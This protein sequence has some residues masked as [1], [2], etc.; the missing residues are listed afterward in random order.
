[1]A[2][3]T[4]TSETSASA[5]VPSVEKVLSEGLEQMNAGKL[6]AA[7]TA[8]KFVLGEAM[9]QERLGLVRTA[10]GYLAAIEARLQEQDAA[11]AEIPEMSAQLLLNKKTPAAALEILDKALQ[12]LPERA[13]LSYLKAVAHAQLE[14]GQEAA[15]ALAK[16]VEL[17]ADFLFQFRLEPD[18]ENLRHTGPFAALNRG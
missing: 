7:G 3:K 13:V 15:D 4:K 17:D 10:R 6:V 16:A 5:P 14:Q 12:A 8:F 11:P 18:F 9:T 1:M 2:T